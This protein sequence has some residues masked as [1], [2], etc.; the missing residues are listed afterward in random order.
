MK[1]PAI[2]TVLLLSLPFAVA[3]GQQD[4]GKRQPSPEIMKKYDVDGDGRLNDSERD[5]LRAERR[6]RHKPPAELIEKYDADGDGQLN[7]SERDALRAEKRAR[8]KPPA[9]LIEK[10]DMDGDGRLNDSERDVLRA[11]MKAKR[12]EI[13]SRYDADGDG[14]LNKAEKQ[15]AR[16]AGAFKGMHRRGKRHGKRGAP[17]AGDA[18]NDTAGE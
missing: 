3:G 14:E 16:D 13:I 15:A 9:E 17:P 4:G 11:E 18:P 1:N 8:H 10:Y 6:V 12:A 7:D 5:A 2:L